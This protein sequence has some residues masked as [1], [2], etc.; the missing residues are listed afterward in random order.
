MDRS[1]VGASDGEFD[2]SMLDKLTERITERLQVEVRRETAIAMQKGDLGGQ[3]ERFLEDHIATNTCPLC[4]DLMAG[5]EHRPMLIFPCGHT[6]CAACLNKH[7]LQKAAGTSTCPLCRQTIGSH[8]VNVSLQ[9]VIDGFVEKQRRLERGDDVFGEAM[10]GPPAR[11]SS[12]A[13]G[14]LFRAGTSAPGVSAAQAEAVR[15]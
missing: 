12:A 9:Q 8:A 6:F 3:V 7:L 4:Y 11:G 1:A 10:G 2:A 15:M 5:K 14:A 13:G